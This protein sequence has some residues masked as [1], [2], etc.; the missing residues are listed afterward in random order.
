V[1]ASDLLTREIND[2]VL[3]DIFF[4]KQ[5]GNW[6]CCKSEGAAAVYKGFALIF[7]FAMYITCLLL[8]M[9]YMRSI[10]SCEDKIIRRIDKDVSCKC[11]NLGQYCK[12][13]WLGQNL[14][15]KS[16]L[17]AR[18]ISY[19]VSSFPFIFM[20]YA[21]QRHL[22]N[23]IN[24]IMGRE[25]DK[26]E[27]YEKVRGFIPSAQ[28]IKTIGS[29]LDKDTLK[30]ISMGLF[31]VIYVFMGILI[32]I[33]D[34]DLALFLNGESDDAKECRKII[35]GGETETDFINYVDGKGEKMNIRI[36]CILLT[37]LN[38]IYF[39]WSVVYTTIGFFS[40]ARN[41]HVEKIIRKE[42]DKSERERRRNEGGAPPVANS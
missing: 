34:I 9:E 25:N 2:S 8:I 23:W 24:G 29:T 32:F 33:L 14:T 22:K 5:I 13:D 42:K 37:S 28:L 20:I 19:I 3:Q 30:S 1:E 10:A 35:N 36:L 16:Y 7:V 26:L 4:D 40:N 17:T 39:A 31:V 15:I 27:K 18:M 11:E 21:K 38:S 41:Q 6:L 12:F